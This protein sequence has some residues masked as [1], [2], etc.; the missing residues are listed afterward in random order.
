MSVFHHL[1]VRKETGEIIEFF[2]QG[3]PPPNLP[4]DDEFGIFPVRPE[5]M[6]D[7]HIIQGQVY[8][9]ETYKVED[10]QISLNKKAETF[11]N[12]TDWLVQRHREQVDLGIETSL[13]H[14]EYG[15]L[16]NERQSVRDSIK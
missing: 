12:K 5:D 9:I 2:V 7:D 1:K 10:T 8:N 11:L 4:D 3:Y 14:Q 6:I 13:S 15:E 16:L